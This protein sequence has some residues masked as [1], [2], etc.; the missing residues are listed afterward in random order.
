LKKILLTGFLSLIISSCVYDLGD[1]TPTTIQSFLTFEAEVSNINTVQKVSLF[2]SAKGLTNSTVS[3][4]INDAK[5][6]VK[7]QNGKI[8]NYQLSRFGIYESVYTGIVGDSYQLFI[9]LK[10]GNKYESN[11]QKIPP[12]TNIDKIYSVPTLKDNLPLT[13]SYRGG[14]DV[15]VDFLDKPEKNYYR[16]KWKH[17][18]RLKFCLYCKYGINR[19]DEICNRSD[20]N[21]A[22]SVQSADLPFRYN[23]GGACWNLNENQNID[24]LD[25]ALLNDQLIQKKNVCRVPYV[26]KSVFPVNRYYLMVEQ[27]SLPLETYTAFKTIA[28]QTEG[29]GTLFDVPVLNRF[30]INLKNI[31]N[32]SEKILG[33]FD[34]HSTTRKL[35]YVDTTVP[36]AGAERINLD[37]RS[38][39]PIS[40]PPPPTA[41][42]KEGSDKTNQAPEGWREEFN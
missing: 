1:Y 29:T 14:Y 23:C 21:A 15:F 2:Y 3:E 26:I 22:L 35:I 10:N 17:Y 36:I 6:Y 34:V 25:D 8:F 40:P 9:E 39:P 41:G 28:T 27:Q 16:W 32:P 7:N 11:S 38:R 19:D 12:V 31:N 24:L 18:E 13:S 37:P 20:D 33:V 4:P 30:S 42:C 5:V